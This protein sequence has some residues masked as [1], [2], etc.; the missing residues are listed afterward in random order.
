[1]PSGAGR[2]FLSASSLLQPMLLGIILSTVFVGSLY[3][4]NKIY[5]CERRLLPLVTIPAI[6][7]AVLVHAPDNNEVCFVSQ[8][9]AVP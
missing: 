2:G 8:V 1:M 9:D 3:V 5:D 6:E 7:S 4:V